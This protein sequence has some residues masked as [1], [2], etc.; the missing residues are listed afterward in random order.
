[1][2]E[3]RSK[4]EKAFQEVLKDKD[5]KFGGRNLNKSINEIETKLFIIKMYEKLTKKKI[6]E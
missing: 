3:Y 1:M 2:D 4:L 5:F 6:L